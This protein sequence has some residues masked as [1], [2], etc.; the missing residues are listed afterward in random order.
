M[1]LLAVRSWLRQ[2]LGQNCRL[3][4]GILVVVRAAR[5]VL[6][7]LLCLF[8]L[9][10]LQDL[11]DRLLVAAL[12][13]V[14]RWSLAVVVGTAGVVL[15]NWWLLHDLWLERNVCRLLRFL[16]RQLDKRSL[17]HR[18]GS[19]L[20]WHLHDLW[21]LWCFVLDLRR[22]RHIKRLNCF[23]LYVGLHRGF[24]FET[25]ESL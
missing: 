7:R 18:H 20:L 17:H 2:R 19:W 21:L 15:V 23:L 14:L 8:G 9:L 25:G 3:L 11:V 1:D 4:V 12:R 16:L 6:V 13:G 10:L 5:A 24:S 22:R